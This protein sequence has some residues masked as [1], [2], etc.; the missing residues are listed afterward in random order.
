MDERVRFSTPGSSASWMSSRLGLSEGGG[1]L[2]EHQGSAE[3]SRDGEGDGDAC[4][5]LR[6]AKASGRASPTRFRRPWAPGG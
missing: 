3:M 1:R 6:N 5:S 4:F 2:V